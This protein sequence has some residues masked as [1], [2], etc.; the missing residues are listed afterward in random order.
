MNVRMILNGEVD[1]LVVSRESSGKS[2]NICHGR[3]QPR[4]LIHRHVECNLDFNFVV[5]LINW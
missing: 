5:P 2:E 3:R 1:D 4:S